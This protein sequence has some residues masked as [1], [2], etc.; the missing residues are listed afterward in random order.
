MEG[1]G[2]PNERRYMRFIGFVLVLGLGFSFAQSDIAQSILSCTTIATPE[3]RLSCYD[4]IAD[5]LIQPAQSSSGKWQVDIDTNPIDDSKTVF[6]ST[7]A[8][9]GKGT[10]GERIT[11][12]LRCQSG[13]V[14]AYIFWNAYIA[15]E[16]AQVTYRIGT[17]E[18]ILGAWYTS[19][20]N[21]A[22]F[23]GLQQANVVK[24]IGELATA[25][26]GRFVAQITPY[27]ESPITAVFNTTGLAEILPQLYEPCPQ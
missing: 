14:E 19:T 7:V 10:Y 21:Q 26:N 12:N 4:A 9:E 5:I 13:S 17:K 1:Q 18:A 25:E 20:D 23:F 15:D 11:L 8:D 16:E 2:L 27:N 6:A 24:F 22:T 3:E